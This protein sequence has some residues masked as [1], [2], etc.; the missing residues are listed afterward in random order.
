MWASELYTLRQEHACVRYDI[1]TRSRGP[2]LDL[3]IASAT[4]MGQVASALAVLTSRRRKNHTFY[5]THPSVARNFKAI[6]EYLGL[7]E[8]DVAALWKVFKKI[9]NIRPPSSKKEL[10]GVDEHV[11]PW[12]M[13]MFLDEE[14]TIF[15]D[16]IYGYFNRAEKTFKKAEEGNGL[17]VSK[18]SFGKFVLSCYNFLSIPSIALPAL[19]FHIYDVDESGA[20]DLAEVMTMLS[21]FFGEDFMSSAN[22]ANLYHSI[23]RLVATLPEPLMNHNEFMDFCRQNPTLLSVVRRLH[24]KMT[25][26]T[27]GTRRWEKLSLERLAL[28]DNSPFHSLEVIMGRQGF[29]LSSVEPDGD[30]ASK[31][32]IK[33]RRASAPSVPSASAIPPRGLGAPKQSFSQQQVS[34]PVVGKPGGPRRASLT[35]APSIP[36]SP[37]ELKDKK[38]SFSLQQVSAPVVGKPDSHQAKSK[39][40]RHEEKIAPLR[41]SISAS[42]LNTVQS[43]AQK[44]SAAFS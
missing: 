36:H 23:E 42:Q 30:G 17:K 21:H 14:R 19:I 43:A 18:I 3:Q 12:Q 38:Q 44:A 5:A 6:F 25:R 20:L 28:Q 37:L 9:S 8:A 39:K 40:N 22:L 11:R 1:Y 27:L 35:S 33:G 13:G 26:Q 29:H 31:A 4:S 24:G 10:L 32:P 2:N 16:A 7:D 15:S 41:R 34:A